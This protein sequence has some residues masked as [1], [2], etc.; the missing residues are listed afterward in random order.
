M[1]SSSRRLLGVLLALPLSLAGATLVGAPADAANAPIGLGTAAS[2]AV[3]GGSTV[4]NTG[5]TV[6]NGDLGLSPG[7]SVTGFPPGTVNGTVHAA[8]AAAST[9]QDDT[10]TAYNTAAGLSATGAITAD[11]GGQVLGPGV[12]GATT[13]ALTGA[14]TLNAAGDPNAVFVFRSDSTLITAAA[15]S[16]VLAGGA[17][18]CNIFWL[19]G[20]SATLGVNSV[21]SGTVAAL[22]A[23]T[24]NTGATVSGRLLARNAA[25]TLDSNSV[26][27]P[28][29]AAA[30]SAPPV[31]ASPS[32]RSS[33]RA[34][35]EG[36][37]SAR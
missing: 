3:L 11:L 18:A 19:V 23:I 32:R 35:S 33:T 22:T 20:S 14:L 15:S 17:S 26:S 16:V 7:T 30:A 8:D 27:L 9:A 12:Y 34:T 10:T 29:C 28:V 2:F 5:P 21:L 25:V 31:A 36:S 13:L 6:V 37:D 24:A 4:T 1:S